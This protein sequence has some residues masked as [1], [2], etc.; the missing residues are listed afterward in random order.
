[1]RAKVLIFATLAGLAACS[2]PNADA[3]AGRGGQQETAARHPQSGL[4]IIPLSVANRAGERHVFAVEVAVTQAQQARGLMFRTALGPGEG[5]LFPLVPP[6]EAS[7]WMKNTVIPLDIIFIGP[8]RR[9]LNIAANTVPY[10]EAPVLSAGRAAAVL[11][12]AG[13]RAAQLGLA[14]G[15]AVDW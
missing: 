6:R 12:L 9:I 1:M 2:P 7:F 10:S 3:G 14:P 13:G 15:D 5:M 11:E 4:S 8:D